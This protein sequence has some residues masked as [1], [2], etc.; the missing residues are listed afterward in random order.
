MNRI[1][2][3]AEIAVDAE[4]DVIPQDE[5]MPQDESPTV[6]PEID[7]DHLRMAEA[8]LFAASEP[9]SEQ[10]LASSD[11]EPNNGWKYILPVTGWR[12]YAGRLTDQPKLNWR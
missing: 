3:F 4:M 7:P 5:I 1:V 2:R 11:S 10:A 8:L 12:A 9:L 6:V